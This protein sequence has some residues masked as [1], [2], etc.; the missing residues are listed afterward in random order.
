MEIR[1]EKEEKRR[2]EKRDIQKV[3][4]MAWPSALESFFVALA[5]IVD[6]YMVSNL[7]SEAVAA[8][9]LTTQPKFIG[10]AP[11]MALKIAISALVAR[12]FGQGDR[13]KANSVMVMGLVFTIIGS[14]LMSVICVIY[15]EP[16]LRFV[17]S[18]QDT[19]EYAV[20]YFRIIMGGMM[21]NT[22][23]LA[24]NA[25]QRGVG[26]TKIAMR[27]NVTANV[28]NVI[29]NYLLIE[30]HLGFPAL[31]VAGAAIA[32]VFGTV[33]AFVMSILSVLKKDSFVSLIYAVKKKIGF[34]ADQLASMGKLFGSEL[35]EQYLV[36]IG[37]L[38]TAMFAAD[39]GTDAFAAHQV[40][41]NF[42]SLT[43][44]LGDGFS[45][46]AVALIGKSL[47]E[48]KTEMAKNYAGIC[49]RFALCLSA[50]MA[51]F[52]LFGGRTIFSLFFAEKVIIEYGV[53]ISRMLMVICLLQMSQVVFTGCLRGAGDMVYVMILGCISV[54]VLRPMSAYLLAYVCELG[55]LGVWCGIMV[56]QG[57]RLLGT[58]LRYRSGKW[59]MI[60][61]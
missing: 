27:T 36:R 6:T 9:G 13:H 60:K 58:Y 47:G 44:A 39:M 8:V 32:T 4:R 2:F 52:F 11:F 15:A 48:E 37:F 40:G 45:V 34:A 35:A 33:V 7:S 12:R 53:I 24:V 51:L 1:A 16:I 41:M 38:L 57:V 28:V 43:F 31:G 3:V 19:H 14:V 26:N 49:H 46:A 21:F 54:A 50:V 25:A 18:Q 61:I 22:I 17:G 56:D 42:M 29:G 5:G 59:T 10:L 30:G 20:T 55:L 23:Q